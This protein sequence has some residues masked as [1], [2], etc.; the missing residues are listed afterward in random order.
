MNLP[1]GLER[2]RFLVKIVQRESSHLRATDERLFASP[3]APERLLSM[4]TDHAKA[5]QLDAFVA[6]FA[7]LHDTVRDKFVPKLLRELQEPVGAVI[8]NLDRAERLG[9]LVSIDGWIDRTV[10]LAACPRVRF[11][12]RCTYS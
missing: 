11:W 12:M 3:L 5:E 6:R 2:L 4:D 10:S 9:W 1:G 8:D 7:R